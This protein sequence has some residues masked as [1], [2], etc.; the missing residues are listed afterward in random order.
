M[1]PRYN[2][3]IPAAVANVGFLHWREHRGVT[4]SYFPECR[5][6]LDFVLI[7]DST[8]DEVLRWL[9]VDLCRLPRMEVR[10][11]VKSVFRQTAWLYLQAKVL[12]RWASVSFQ[13]SQSLGS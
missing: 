11:T 9:E 3:Q 2:I 10:K 12:G 1:G 7:A 4:H 13:F 5:K 6:G 8:S